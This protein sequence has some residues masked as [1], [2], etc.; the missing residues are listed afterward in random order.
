MD[1][2]RDKPLATQTVATCMEVLKKDLD[3]D[4]AVS[5]LVVG[6]EN[7]QILVL[8][9]AGSSIC[10]KWE[11]PSAPTHMAITG[12]RDVE[13]RIVVACRDG[14]VHTI[15]ENGP[16]GLVIE[17]E[18]IACGLVRL[19]KSIIVGCMTN[20]VHAFSLRGKKMYSIYLPAPIVNMELLELKKTRAAKAMMVAMGTGEVRLYNDK[21]LLAT[22]RIDEPV[23]ACR[24]GSYGREE[25]C[26]AVIGASGALTIKIL[27]R[28][29]KFES[30]SAVTGPPPEQDVPLSIPKK[31]KLYVEQTQR[32]RE[33]ATEMHRIFQRDLC[34][35]RLAT[36]RAYVKMIT[37]GQGPLSFSSGAVLRLT[38]QVQGLGPRFKIKLTLQ[39]T[40]TKHVADLSVVINYNALLYKVKS[41]VFRVPILIPGVGYRVDVELE[42]I[43]EN[44]AS[45]TVRVFVCSA[46]S[47]VPVLSAVV[48]MPAS[49][50]MLNTALG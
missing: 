34:K 24:F 21:S 37:D 45:D 1:E 13:F 47:R 38:A 27:Q 17:L 23:T 5:M 14:S 33:Q 4:D 49:E 28:S 32:E 16:S 25:G 10:R 29:F 11:L 12:T 42:C 9:P 35:L 7:G 48:N 20:T 41:S 19:E 26:L 6:C 2:Q 44:G 22:L 30:T 43:D 46:K 18:S 39:N 36:A 50:L 15:K 40:G 8:D 3:E 31:T